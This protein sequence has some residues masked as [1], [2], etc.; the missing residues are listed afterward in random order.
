MLSVAREIIPFQ[1]SRWVSDATHE[2]FGRAIG[3]S[4]NQAVS[5]AEVDGRGRQLRARLDGMEGRVSTEMLLFRRGVILG[6]GSAAV[7][8]RAA[9]L[10]AV[11]IFVLASAPPV[12]ACQSCFGAEDSPLIDGARFGAYALIAVT[13]GVQGA[14]A[15]FFLYLRRRAR[16]ASIQELD[17][18]WG[19]LQK[20]SR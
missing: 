13:L 2:D 7:I 6:G 9:G 19:E 10:I 17:A 5:V 15:A 18:E 11:V 1:A 12:Q 14:F 16:A 4:G 20:A 3:V 8:R